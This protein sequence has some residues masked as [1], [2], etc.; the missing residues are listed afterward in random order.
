VL[1]PCW[2]KP[3]EHVFP[4]ALDRGQWELFFGGAGLSA[5]TTDRGCTVSEADQ[6]YSRVT[7]TL[8]YILLM[9]KFA[10]SADDRSILPAT[11][12]NCAQNCAALYVS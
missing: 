8:T 3:P 12:R 7:S 1:P 9:P 2:T 10:N 5:A 11:Q 6:V 4:P